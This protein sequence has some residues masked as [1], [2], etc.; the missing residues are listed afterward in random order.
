[1]PNFF[2]DITILLGDGT[3]DF[4]AAPTSPESVDGVPFAIAVG[5]FNGDGDGDLAVGDELS[6]EIVILL[7]DGTGDFAAAPTSPEGTGV[8]PVAIA[9]GDFDGDGDLDLAV[10]RL[11]RRHN[12]AGRRQRRL[13]RGPDEPRERR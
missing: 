10:T 2:G 12:S 6:D 4:S 11:R 9:V 8:G 7:G 3:G 13:H 1:M 5:D